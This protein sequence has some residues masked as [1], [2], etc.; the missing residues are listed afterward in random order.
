MSYLL[1]TW[2]PG[3]PALKAGALQAR[4]EA[5]GGWTLALERFCLRVYVRGRAA[6][7]VTLLPRGGVLIGSLFDR[8]ATEAGTVAAYDLRHLND[9]DGVSVARRA[10]G[11]AWGR[12]VLVLPVRE[13][14]PVVARDPLG[15]LD[16]LIWRRGDTWF[17]AD[18]LTCGSLAP[19]DL[20]I[21]EAR[22][23]DLIAEPDLA[24]A[25]IPLT[26]LAAVRPGTVIDEAAKVHVLWTPAAFARTPRLDAGTAADRIPIITQ[27]CVAALSAQHGEILCEISGGLDSAIVAA[28]LKAAGRRPARGINFHWAQAE[29]DERPYARAVAKAVRARLEIVAC[30]TAPI[31]ADAFDPV[32]AARPS[33]N[34]VDPVYDAALADRLARGGEGAL[35]TG[36]GGDAVFYQMPA[37]QLALDLLARGPRRRGLAALSRRTDR[38][39]W[40][41]LAAAVRPPARAVFPY[42]RRRSGQA[43]PRHPWLTG[44]SGVG[45]AKRI[46]I[47]A[48]VANQAVFGA[49]RRGAVAEVIHPLLSQPLVELCLSTP[50]AIL[51]GGEQDRAFV[52]SA[53]R[54]QIPQMVAERQSKGDLSVF[55][56]RGVAESLEILRPRLLEGRLA[57]RGLIDVE[58]LAD[59]MTPEAMIWRDGSAE[60]LCL[61]VLEAWVRAWESRGA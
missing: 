37:A 4:I 16:A 2:P 40:S 31:A 49:S 44:L 56:A 19:E 54:G 21:D 46:Q 60:F 52:R 42:G 55:F 61:A 26:G 45:L 38:S 10:V 13:R 9:E 50:A 1:M 43:P 25:D 28:C 14:R 33:F 15:A 24:S 39:V 27:A 36:Q 5:Q 57:V 53:F 34:A 20:A 7:A 12:Y 41:L 3:E 59:A 51:G 35:F 48:L 8:A 22:L 29:A 30:R 11:E 32:A 58:A 47:E 17:V 23:L 6:P 18:D